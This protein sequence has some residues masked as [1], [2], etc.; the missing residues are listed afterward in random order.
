M[1]FTIWS[2][3]GGEIH[4]TDMDELPSME[5]YELLKTELWE[6]LPKADPELFDLAI[7]LTTAFDTAKASAM[8]SGMAK[9][10]LARDRVKL[11]GEYVGLANRPRNPE[12]I[13]A[14]KKWPRCMS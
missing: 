10:Q 8:S 11:V 3:I 4:H 6:K 5:D 13:R 7:P 12:I 14:T 2:K 1:R 9:F